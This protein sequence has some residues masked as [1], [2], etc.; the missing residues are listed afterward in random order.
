MSG[1]LRSRLMSFVS[2]KYR[3]ANPTRELNIS[4]AYPVKIS[5]I[6]GSRLMSSISENYRLEN[7]V[8]EPIISSA[9]P[10]EG[11]LPRTPRF[12]LVP[13]VPRRLKNSGIQI[14]AASDSSGEIDHCGMDDVSVSD[15]F[16]FNETDLAS[17]ES[18]W[19]L[20]ER[21]MSFHKVFRGPKKLKKR[22]KAFKDSVKVVHESNTTSDSCRF[23]LNEFADSLPSESCCHGYPRNYI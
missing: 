11:Q 1:I 15:T 23:A 17:E 7:P 9:S 14:T 8:E 6:L 13:A 18:L 10:V 3:L 2:K 20:Y 22:F 12:I 19:A 5:A 16:K 21:W 4:S